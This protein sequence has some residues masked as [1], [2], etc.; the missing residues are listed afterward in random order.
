MKL[1]LNIK[2]CTKK[3]ERV[4]YNAFVLTYSHRLLTVYHYFCLIIS[5]NLFYISKHFFHVQLVY[6]FLF[7]SDGLLNNLSL[8]LADVLVL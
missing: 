1:F 2:K 3:V 5:H 6:F 4:L 8:Q 7:L